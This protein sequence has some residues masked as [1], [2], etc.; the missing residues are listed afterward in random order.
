LPLSILTDFEEFAVYDCRIRPK[1]TDK[2]DNARVIYL[3]YKQY[4]DQWNKIADIFSKDAILKGSFDKFAVTTKGK[5]GRKHAKQVAALEL[6]QARVFEALR[7]NVVSVAI[8]STG[9]E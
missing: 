2:A 4:A 6:I 5:R 3:T 7:K 8:E 1:H 9:R